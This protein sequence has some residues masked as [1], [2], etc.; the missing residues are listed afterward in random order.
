MEDEM[1]HDGVR[2]SGIEACSAA[3]DTEAH[4][5]VVFHDWAHNGPTV[6][7]QPLSMIEVDFLI[8]DLIE[9]QRVAKDLLLNYGKAAN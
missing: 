1:N 5:F 6:Q 7:S 4:V 3:S 2:D 9:A 8:D